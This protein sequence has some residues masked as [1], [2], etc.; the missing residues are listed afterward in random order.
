MKKSLRMKSSFAVL[1]I[2]SWAMARTTASFAATLQN[3][4]VTRPATTSPQPPAQGTPAHTELSYGIDE[5]VK[6]IDAGVDTATIEAYI[7]SSPTAYNPS[8]EDV[9]QLHER[10]VP[11][12]IITALIRHGKALRE[13]FAQSQSVS[14]AQPQQPPP[15]NY[16]NSQPAQPTYVP[17]PVR[18]TYYYTYPNY[19]YPVY[20]PYYPSY[21]YVYASPLYYNYS[22]GGRR[23]YPFVGSG[24]GRSFGRVG[25][26]GGGFHGGGF[27]ASGGFGHGGRGG[28]FRR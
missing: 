27:H 19:S 8:A 11:S 1:L 9:I 18:E 10:G 24:Y 21:S 7:Q 25:W 26:H 15:A 17:A 6:M 20:Y 5:I 2:A 4:K 3:D 12:P 16:G 28:G 23:F 13:K 14:P 22:F